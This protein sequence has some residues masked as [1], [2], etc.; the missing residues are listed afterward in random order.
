MVAHMERTH[1]MEVVP[2]LA[3]FRSGDPSFIMQLLLAEQRTRSWEHA[4][5]VVAA[6]MAMPG[7]EDMA[8]HFGAAVPS[9]R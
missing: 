4:E 2:C 5:D 6:L 1:Y 9:V 7:N 3:A 8:A